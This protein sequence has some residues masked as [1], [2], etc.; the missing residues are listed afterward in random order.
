[1][2]PWGR[3]R[4]KDSALADHGGC[5]GLAGGSVVAVADSLA[6]VVDLLPD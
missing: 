6:G 2:T 1:M 5:K 4:M 3:R